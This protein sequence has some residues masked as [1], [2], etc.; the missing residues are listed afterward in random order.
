[1]NKLPTPTAEK[2]PSAWKGFN[3][4]TMFYLN[5]KKKA[6][7]FEEGD[8]KLISEWGFNFVRLPVDYRIIIKGKDWNEMDEEAMRQMDR[9]VELG[10]AYNVHTCI[11]LH[12]APGYT[13][14]N[15]PE[16]TN[17]WTDSEPQ[18]AFARMW[19]FFAQ[20]YKGTPNENLSFN[21]INEPQSIDDKAYSAVIKKAAAAIREKDPQRLLIADGLDWAT[22]PSALLRGLGVAQATRGYE[23]HKLTHYKAE[24]VGGADKYPL[25]QWPTDETMDEFREKNYR[26][27]EDLKNSGC[28]VVVGEWGAH[29]KTPH[30]VVLRWMKNM[31][32]IF[33]QAGLGWALWNL[34]GSFG[35]LNSGRADVDYED[36]RGQ[37]LDRKMLDLLLEYV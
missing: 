7:V 26:A 32:T 37:K 4:L 29:N 5:E 25:P 17:L 11:N 1:M 27:W 10:K 19:A 36:F 20:R 33:K 18:E 24:W 31:L 15:P 12:R 28:G 35:V 21:F 6:H 16:K 30:D 14:A 3:L 8:F 2:L 23:P 34:K 9:A 13:V 22:K